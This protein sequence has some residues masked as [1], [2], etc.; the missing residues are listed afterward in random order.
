MFGSLPTTDYLSVLPT[1][2]IETSLDH[3]SMVDILSS[4]YLANRLLY[5]I[6]SVYSQ[7]QLDFNKTVKKKKRFRF[8]CNHLSN[9]ASRIVSLTSDNGRNRKT[10]AKIVCFLFSI[11]MNSIFSEF[12]LN[13]FRE[14]EFESLELDSNSTPIIYGAKINL[15]RFC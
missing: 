9:V 11:T 7:F 3:I 12:T 10:N 5:S 6:C 4:V 13:Y 2:L 14:N 8:F 1:E 15:H